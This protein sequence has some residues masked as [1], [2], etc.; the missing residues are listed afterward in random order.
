MSERE[1]KERLEHCE[2]QLRRIKEDRDHLREASSDFG[3]LAERLSE[4]IRDL[5]QQIEQLQREQE[6]SG[7]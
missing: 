4:Q 6:R 2:T 3:D 5:R 1:L 7:R